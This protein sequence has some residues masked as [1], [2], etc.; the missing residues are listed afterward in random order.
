V[1]ALLL[2]RFLQYHH[3]CIQHLK[4]HTTTTVIKNPEQEE[5]LE[6]KK[7]EVAKIVVTGGE[8]GAVNE[9]ALE[10]AQLLAKKDE[11]ELG[12]KQEGSSIRMM[13]WTCLKK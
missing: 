11:S 7:S 3:Q 13:Y 9:E 8:D 10:Y 12:A 5:E 2:R 4:T 6:E 1:L